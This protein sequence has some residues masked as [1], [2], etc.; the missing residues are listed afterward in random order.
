[1]MGDP[2]PEKVQRVTAC[3]MAIDKRAFDIEELEAAYE[4]R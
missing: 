3:F 1:M 4:G 2:D